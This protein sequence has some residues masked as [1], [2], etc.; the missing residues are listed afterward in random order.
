MTTITQGYRYQLVHDDGVD[1]IV[2]Q[3]DAGNGIWQP[4]SVWMIPPTAPR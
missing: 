1:F 3:H 4:V 2:Y